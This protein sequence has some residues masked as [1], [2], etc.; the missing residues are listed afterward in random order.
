[1][2]YFEACLALWE[3][4][5][6]GQ[7]AA[8]AGEIFS[9]FKSRFFDEEIGILR[10][11]FGPAWEVSDAYKSGRLD[12]G[13]MAEWT[14]LISRYEKLTGSDLS[15]IASN[16]MRAATRLGRTRTAPFLVDEMSVD[17]VPLVDRRRFWPQ[18]ELLKAYITRAP[19]EG[20]SEYLNA[21][22][23]L[24]SALSKTYLADAHRGT[25][26]DAFD[27]KGNFNATQI[28][29]SSLYHLW[30]VIVELYGA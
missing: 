6:H 3:I 20:G 1:M 18:A 14:W 2:H 29:G 27:L 22:D 16:L 10:E 19:R 28:P 25:W 4:G 9:L 8:R 5:H 7:H 21:A 24:A 15:A 23:D 11:F 17:G 12:P 13:H 26:R 30:T